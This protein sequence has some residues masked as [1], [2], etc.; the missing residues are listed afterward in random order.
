M[1]FKPQTQMTLWSRGPANS[2]DKL[3]PF[4]LQYHSA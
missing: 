1:A 4:Y 2:R 3:E